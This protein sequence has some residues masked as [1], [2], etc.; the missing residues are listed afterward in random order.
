MGRELFRRPGDTNDCGGINTKRLAKSQTHP[1]GVSEAFQPGD[2][3]FIQ[4][5]VRHVFHSDTWIRVRCFPNEKRLTWDG[6]KGWHNTL[7]THPDSG[8]T[9][10]G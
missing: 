3:A 8:T 9:T 1:H 10:A 4:T 6:L 2:D 7:A 5:R